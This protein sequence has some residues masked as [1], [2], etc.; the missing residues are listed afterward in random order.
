[1]WKTMFDNPF[2]MFVIILE[3]LSGLIR[4]QIRNV[5]VVFGEIETVSLMT[6]T[7]KQN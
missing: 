2:V 1:M 5:A 6:R 7:Q 4:H 3:E